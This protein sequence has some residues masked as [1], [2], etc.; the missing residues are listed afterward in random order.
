M[1]LPPSVKRTNTLRAYREKLSVEKA[2]NSR[3]IFQRVFATTQY[4]FVMRLDTFTRHKNTIIFGRARGARYTGKRNRSNVICWN[5]DFILPFTS[6]S[7][8]EDLLFLFELFFDNRP[9]K[10]MVFLFS[11]DSRHQAR[12]RGGDRGAPPP[13]A[14]IMYSD[15]FIFSITLYI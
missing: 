15:N 10:Y 8:I 7:A 5:F 12:I 2:N 6:S 9:H 11:Q 13:L 1:R 4:V 3:N 14:Y